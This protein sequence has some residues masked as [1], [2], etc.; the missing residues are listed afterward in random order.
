MT[1]EEEKKEYSCCLMG[2]RP[3]HGCVSRGRTSSLR[4]SK[5]NLLSIINIASDDVW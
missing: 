1:I 4:H 3:V 2:H 5:Y